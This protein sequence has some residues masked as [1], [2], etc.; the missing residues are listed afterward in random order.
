MLVAALMVEYNIDIK[1]V[2]RHSDIDPER[3]QD[4]GSKFPWELFK[5]D[6]VE[7][8]KHVQKLKS[9]G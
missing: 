6:V 8:V 7:A 4:P 3:K 5:K 1:N 2:V 9:N